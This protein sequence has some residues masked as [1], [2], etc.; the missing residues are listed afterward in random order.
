[1]RTVMECSPR[2]VVLRRKV[3]DAGAKA[4]VE[5]RKASQFRTLLSSP[6]RSEIHTHSVRIA[7]EATT[8]LKGAYRA[9]Y[10]RKAIHTIRVDPNVRRVEVGDGTF[11]VR[12]ASRVSR[13]I[14]GRASSRKVDVELE[15]FVLDEREG[16]VF[17]DHHGH[18]AKFAHKLTRGALEAYPRR[19]LAAAELV[20]EPEMARDELVDC[21]REA[22]SPG[23]IRGDVRDLEDTITVTDMVRIYAPVIEARLVG[24]K[25]RV[26]ILRIDAISRR[27]LKA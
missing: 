5:A 15:E 20:R 3:D 25:R 2:N 23:P 7:Y 27:V 22:I 1:M 6:A 26:R 14:S 8:M 18:V 10:R 11:D 12:P 24:P 19:V 21:L 13:A 4:T 9:S 17:V 16:T